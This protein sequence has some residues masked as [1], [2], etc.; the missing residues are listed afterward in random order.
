MRTSAIFHVECDAPEL[1]IY[2][3]KGKIPADAKFAF[4]VGFMSTEQILKFEAE[5]VVNIRGGK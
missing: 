5:I 2:P 4:T 3:M 1:T